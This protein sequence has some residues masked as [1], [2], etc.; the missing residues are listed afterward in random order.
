MFS[1]EL[2]E[3]LLPPIRRKTKQIA[4]LYRLLLLP[5]NIFATFDAF[6]A[7]T[8]NCLLYSS[9][10]LS[11]EKYLQ[12]EFNSNGI[13]IINDFNDIDALYT[14]W[15]YENQEDPIIYFLSE[16]EQYPFVYFL[17]EEEES[18]NYYD[19]IVRAPSALASLTDE[20][21]AVVNKLKLAGKRYKIE[22]Y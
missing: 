3:K 17:L 15:L 10:T 1:K 20:I 18:Q 21:R 19:F 12:L 11:L 22:L 8:N 5:R 14:F 9:Q 2:I 4:W 16:E 13:F 7:R 6:R